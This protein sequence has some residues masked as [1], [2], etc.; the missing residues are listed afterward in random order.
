MESCRQK[1]KKIYMCIYEH[2]FVWRKNSPYTK[3]S[4]EMIFL[5]EK[6]KEKKRE[7]CKSKESAFITQSSFSP[8]RKIN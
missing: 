7:T 1:I 3:N 8:G 4:L 2:V 5:F 6:K